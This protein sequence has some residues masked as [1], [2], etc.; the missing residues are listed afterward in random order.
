MNT[1]GSDERE[2][3]K[4]KRERSEIQITVTIEAEALLSTLVE[5][6]NDGFEMSRVSRKDLASYLLVKAA[7]DFNQDDI[8]RVRSRAL[9]DVHLLEHLLKEARSTGVIPAELRDVLWK[10][11][12]LAPGG[13][14]SKRAG[15]DKGINDTYKEAE[16]A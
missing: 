14:K 11:I 12:N 5:Q 2:K 3:R 15:R 7:E 6:V 16:V 8:S 4:D 1:D 9:T 10:N 13:R